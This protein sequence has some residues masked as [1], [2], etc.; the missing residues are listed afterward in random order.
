VVSVVSDWFGIEILEDAHV[1][2]GK[3]TTVRYS[4]KLGGC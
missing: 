3:H 1:V 2:D 4:L